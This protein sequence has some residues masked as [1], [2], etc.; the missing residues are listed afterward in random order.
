MSA[1]ARR[2]LVPVETQRSRELRYEMTI[3]VHDE[4]P[5]ALSVAGAQPYVKRLGPVHT[6]VLS[7]SNQTL[8]KGRH[9]DSPAVA[10]TSRAAAYPQPT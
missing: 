9:A 7:S 6:G 5:H 4:G 3:L 8:T 10:G 1:A 2:H